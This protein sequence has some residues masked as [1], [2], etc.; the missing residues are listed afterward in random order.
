MIQIGGLGAVIARRQSVTDRLAALIP[1]RDIYIIP[2]RRNQTAAYPRA[3]RLRLKAPGLQ[4][5]LICLAM[6]AVATLIGL[7]FRSLGFAVPT[8]ISVY[9]LSVLIL[10]GDY[11][12]VRIAR[13]EHRVAGKCVIP[14]D[15]Q[16]VLMLH[17]C[18]AASADDVMTS[19][20][21]E[22]HPIDK[23]GAACYSY[24]YHRKTLENAMFSRVF[25]LPGSCFPLFFSLLVGNGL[26][27]L[28]HAL[29]ACLPHLLT[30][31]AF[32]QKSAVWTGVG[33]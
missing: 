23:A 1:E 25:L 27:K 17:G 2:E 8:I 26:E 6:M 31:D 16:A 32:A 14:R 5:V 9:I 22:E 10:S 13:I 19:A 15:I 21:V 3:K 28:F 30:D 4:D 18:A 12:D 29:G 11:A 20:R 33:R 24:S 7:L